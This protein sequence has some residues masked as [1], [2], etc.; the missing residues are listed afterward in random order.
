MATA[1]KKP[2][3]ITE[4]QYNG[5][6]HCACQYTFWDIVKPVEVDKCPNHAVRQPLNYKFMEFMG[7]FS[8][9]R[10]GLVA[11]HCTLLCARNSCD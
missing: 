9:S 4:I 2:T 10:T 5:I 7:V 11:L 1:L 6:L 3:C 8:N